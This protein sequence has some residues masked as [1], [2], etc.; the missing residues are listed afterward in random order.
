MTHLIGTTTL[1]I[2]FATYIL[3]YMPQVLL[4]LKRKSTDGLS[5]LMH[6]ILV[7]GYIADMIY[8]FGRH[9]QWQYRAVTLVGLICLALQHFQIGYY[10][11]ITRRYIFV[12]LALVLWLALSIYAIQATLPT[13]IYIDAGLIAWATGV[14]YTL[15]QIWKNHRF[16]SCL[17]VSLTFVWLDI[18]CSTCDTI[19]AWSLGWDYPSKLGSPL[20]LLFGIFL[21]IQLYYYKSKRDAPTLSLSA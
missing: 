21:L 3:L 12:T 15:P 4:N 13:A 11:K 19:S 2:S 1:N 7:I 10:Q 14:V 6:S 17:G 8:G 5:F 20:E 9:M 16:A 18:M